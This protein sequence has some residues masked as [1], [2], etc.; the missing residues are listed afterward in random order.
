LIFFFQIIK[1]F[2]NFSL[3]KNEKKNEKNEK[4]RTKG[5]QKE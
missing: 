1:R 4:R 2:S 3:E 5:D